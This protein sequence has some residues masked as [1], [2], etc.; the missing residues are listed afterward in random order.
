M[1]RFRF[2]A[3]MD[4]II[5]KKQ[6]A[7]MIKMSRIAVQVQEER[8]DKIDKELKVL[9]KKAHDIR[10]ANMKEFESILTR[11]QKKILKQM[12]KEGR[13]RY[14]AQHPWGK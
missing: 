11:Q 13:N 7:K 4:E 1:C 8:L 3:V 9:E 12:K 10:K 5:S 6:E 2:Y 14:H